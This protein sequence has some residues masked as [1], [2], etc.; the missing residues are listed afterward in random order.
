MD[1]TVNTRHDSKGKLKEH[2]LTH[3]NETAQT[4]AAAREPTQAREP[5]PECGGFLIPESGCWRC[6][7]CGYGRC[8]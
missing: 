4:D 3:G 6:V 1:P 7:L 2:A 8:S 5:C